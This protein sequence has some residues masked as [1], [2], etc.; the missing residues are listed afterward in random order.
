MFRTE[1]GIDL[2]PSG[3]PEADW[4]QQKAPHLIVPGH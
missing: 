2:S 3:P 4:R 1:V